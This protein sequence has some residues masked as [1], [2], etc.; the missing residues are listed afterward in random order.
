M[1]ISECFPNKYMPVTG[2]FI[3]SQ[4]KALSEYCNVKVIVPLRY[5]PPRE[6]FSVNIFK[7]LINIY[8]WF[9]DLK[10]TENFEEG[11]LK[12]IYFG[13]IS[14]PRPDFETSESRFIRFFFYNRIKK[15]MDNANPDVIYCN[16]LR[17]WADVCADYS[18]SKN[19]PF[20]IDHH[21]DIPTL[22]KLFP[23]RYKSF[24][25]VLD[26]AD[27]VIVH[28]TFNKTQLIAEN[29]NLKDI[30]LIYLGQNFKVSDK[31]KDFNFDKI[32]L[33]C[34]SHLNEQ[35][36]NIDI[37]IKAVKIVNEKTEI[38]LVIAGDG[39][40][41]NNYEKLVHELSLTANV[42]FAGTKTQAE[43]NDMY[44]NADIFIL[45]SYP[46]AFGIVFIEAMAKGLPV[47]TC[48][49]NGGGEEIKLLGYPAVFSIPGSA[50]YLAE[51][52]L[53]LLNDR[54]KMSEM[55]AIGKHIVKNHFTWEI[56]AMN[57]FNAI[58][59]KISSGN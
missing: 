4:A 9:K 32:K 48:E 56:N 11:R 10:E 24:L 54:N 19:I 2:E 41:K 12:V 45:P 6:L 22:K 38:E 14:F 28:S 37:L 17:P 40:L 59:E 18:I 27:K 8:K 29:Q 43:L 1:E 26:K 44:D 7:S 23:G 36:K 20:I 16:W 33:I 53:T 46:E 39:V 34:V 55:S 57:T 35:R 25:G 50:E 3:Y 52:V 49:G 15:L 30:E 47:I 42:K 21:E 51:S 13:Y 58:T 31:V 5:V